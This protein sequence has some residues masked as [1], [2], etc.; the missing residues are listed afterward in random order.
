MLK[1]INRGK[2]VKAKIVFVSQGSGTNSGSEILNGQCRLIADT[3]D[4]FN[5]NKGRSTNC[6]FNIYMFCSDLSDS[7]RAV[8]DISV[9]MFQVK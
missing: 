6:S 4:E 3:G 5:S 9:T 8:S 2:E 1:N 7:I